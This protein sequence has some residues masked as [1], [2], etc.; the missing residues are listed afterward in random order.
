MR[1]LPSECFAEQAS[2]VCAEH[3]RRIRERLPG[4]DVRHVGGTSIPGVLT[5]G[6]VDLHV[7][8]EAQAF[9]A[10]RDALRELYEPLDEAGWKE[11]A[12]FFDPRSTPRVE[13]SLTK[14]G[15]I[16]DLHNGEAWRR[17]AQDA[18]LV[19]RYNALKRAH[20]GCSVEAYAAQKREFF[21]RNFRL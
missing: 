8:V 10:A 13:I 20:E 21:H 4:V 12:Y 9:A 5:S 16:D 2:L 3:S 1:F 6:D 11:S 14:I 19:E 15:G 18:S 7:R 17:I